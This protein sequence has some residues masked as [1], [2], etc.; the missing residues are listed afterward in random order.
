M[1]LTGLVVR[2]PKDRNRCRHVD[3]AVSVLLYAW[4]LRFSRTYY[5]ESGYMLSSPMSYLM[6]MIVK[7]NWYFLSYFVALQAYFN[8]VCVF[9]SCV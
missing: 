9:C 6:L 1:S 7:V 5:P 2:M 8:G 4:P 3:L